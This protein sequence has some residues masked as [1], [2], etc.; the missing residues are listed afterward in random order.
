MT[1]TKLKL[2]IWL[3]VGVL[4]CSVVALMR[5]TGTIN[6]NAFY[7]I[8]E[9]YDFGKSDLTSSSPDCI[10]DKETKSFT[11]AD[12][13][14]VKK[15]AKMTTQGQWNYIQF[16]VDALNQENA[17]WKIQYLNGA[18]EIIS[19]QEYTINQGEHL[20]PISCPQKFSYLRIRI[21]NQIGLTFSIQ[22]M[23]LREK[24]LAV[25]ATD[26]LNLFCQNVGIYVLLTILI[27]AILKLNWYTPVMI[28]Q[29][30]YQL[31]GD[32][33]GKR[34]QKL[35]ERH[36]NRL[37][38]L[39]FWFLFMLVII[40]QATALYYDKDAYKYNVLLCCLSLILIGL[41]SWE[42]PLQGLSWRGVLP[43][44][45][46]VFW[47]WACVSD[48][49]VSKY[50]K[51]TGYAM[52]LGIGF[53]FFLWNQSGKSKK[54][55]HNMIQGME[56]TLP[57]V[58]VYCIFFRLKKGGIIYNGGFANR[59][60]MSFYAL[61]LLI[62]FLTELNYVLH[63]KHS[64]RFLKRL[65]VFG[66][67]ASF[68]AYFI[69]LCWTPICLVAALVVLLL[70]IAIQFQTRKTLLLGTVKTIL[71]LAWALIISAGVLS[72]TLLGMENVPKLLNTDFQYKNE[73]QETKLTELQLA[74]LRNTEPEYLSSVKSI[75]RQDKQLIWKN[76][77]RKLNLMGN[78]DR[79][80]VARQRTASYNGFL[81]ISYR[82][83]LFVLIPYLLLLYLCLKKA[84]RE[85][86]FL[87]VAITISF[88]L[89]LLTE[90][91]ELPFASPLWVLFYL[92]MGRW[93]GRGPM[94][95]EESD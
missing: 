66:T 88:G 6:L 72:V 45:W 64:E 63:S 55:W 82:Y 20:V 9:V 7:D 71:T 35:D 37:R 33:W 1:K 48:L 25:R 73:V 54:I 34:F 24:V 30:A 19:E 78:E 77:F 2:Y 61:G 70:W 39:L 56:W 53:F 62:V 85:K 22:S 13:N 27:L 11:I 26:V 59:Q 16:Y 5:T 90:N 52:F 68:A 80:V 23:Q 18:K 95:L 92:G 3:F 15:F 14:A 67:G 29:Y 28:L 91:I 42:K 60:D 47:L 65:A 38:I 84:C 10:Y 46:F 57:I 69:Y 32:Y 87:S 43:S 79:L 89:L 31:F 21:K 8:G 44:A 58:V 4:F 83:G 41:L 75:E 49:F 17:V 12:N 86:N 51:F 36:R 81:E 93:F 74:Q 50:F 94:S 40:W 76:Y